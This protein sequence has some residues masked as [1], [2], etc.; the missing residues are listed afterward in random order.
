MSCPILVD[1]LRWPASCSGGGR[2][3]PARGQAEASDAALRDRVTQLVE[4]LDADKPE[5]RDAAMA[6]LTKLGPKIL[7]LLPDA[8]TLPAGER[9]D[10]VE[11]LRAALRKAEDDINPAASRV[12]L[13]GKGIRL[14]EAMQQLQKQ[15]GNAITDMREQL[16]ADVTNPRS[17]CRSATSRSSRRWP[18]SRGRPR[19]TWTSTPATA[20][21]ASSRAWPAGSDAADPVHRAVPHR[22][23]ADRR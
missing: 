10:R 3:L 19:S 7:P 5:A 11:K 4:R 22:A 9:K 18:R 6:A 15:T 8:A 20:R 23:Q 13:E 21:S 17:T 12:T 2:G 14:T 1:R 16:G